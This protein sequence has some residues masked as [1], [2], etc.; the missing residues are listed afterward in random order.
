M[1]PHMA[2]T[3]SKGYP[4]VGDVEQACPRHRKST[5]KPVSLGLGSRWKK[6]SLQVA[7]STADLGWQSPLGY[8]PS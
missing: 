6:E 4:T 8:S 2:E 1:C 5:E 3:P 7:L